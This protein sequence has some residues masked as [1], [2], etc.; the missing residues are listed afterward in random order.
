MSGTKYGSAKTSPS[1]MKTKPL[2]YQNLKNGSVG[3]YKYAEG[4]SRSNK[5]GGIKLVRDKLK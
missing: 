4:S 5:N 1:S 2:Y 3:G